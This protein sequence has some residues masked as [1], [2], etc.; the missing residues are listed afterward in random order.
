LLYLLVPQK[1]LFNYFAFQ[2][3]VYERTWWTGSFQKRAMWTKLGI[4]VLIN[5]NWIHLVCISILN[6]CSHAR[7]VGKDLNTNHWRIAN[8]QQ[9][10]PMLKMKWIL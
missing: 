10:P 3:L 5:I 8:Q 4:Y 2:S 1:Q 9:R 6:C 7:T